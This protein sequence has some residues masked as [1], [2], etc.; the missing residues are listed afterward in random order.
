MGGP[1]E[2]KAFF[3]FGFKRFLDISIVSLIHR[4]PLPDAL[5]LGGTR[6]AWAAIQSKSFEIVSEQERV[7]D[8]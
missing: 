5:L 1:L 2:S 4:S 3:G 6:S 8:F 7:V